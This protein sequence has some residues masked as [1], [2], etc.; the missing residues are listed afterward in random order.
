RVRT[1]NNKNPGGVGGPKEPLVG[2]EPCG[3]RLQA[4]SRGASRRGALRAHRTTLRAS[5]SG[6]VRAWERPCACIGLPAALRA[7]GQFAL[8]SGPARSQRQ[9]QLLLEVAR[10]DLVEQL[11]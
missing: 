2:I 6:T 4:R 10:R 5:R 8:G 1:K 11:L 3:N 9:R 7:P